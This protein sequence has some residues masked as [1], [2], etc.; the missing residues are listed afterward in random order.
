MKKY[1][2]LIIIYFINAQEIALK[3]NPIKTNIL[4]N[5]LKSVTEFEFEAEKCEALTFPLNI[6]SE[7]IDIIFNSIIENSLPK[8]N[9]EKNNNCYLVS[10]ISKS[11]VISG[12]NSDTKSVAIQIKNSDL[13]D[14]FIEVIKEFWNK[15]NSNKERL[16]IIDKDSRSI[17]ANGPSSQIKILQNYINALEA[18]TKKIEVNV[19]S[20][21][22]IEDI[23]VAMGIN[24]SGIYNRLKTIQANNQNFGFTG[25]SDDISD[26]PT[27]AFPVFSPS[28]QTGNL[29]VDPGNF[30]MNLYP[31][32]PNSNL[33]LAAFPTPNFNLPIVFGGPDLNTRRLNLLLN[34]AETEDKLKVLTRS[35]VVTN[36]DEVTKIFVGQSIPYYFDLL[37]TLQ[38][39]GRSSVTYFYRDIGTSLQ[40]KPTIV[41]ESKIN[42]EIY[43]EFTTINSGSSQV[44]TS[45]SFDSAPIPITPDPINLNW[46]E[47]RDSIT[48]ENGQTVII[49]QLDLDSKI[50]TLIKVPY[51]HRL[52]FVGNLFKGKFDTFA[53]SNYFVLLSA[54]IIE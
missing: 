44:V 4:L 6:R 53:R 41:N 3:N 22:Y 51:A 20:L 42:I 30:V 34:A 40:I 47:L 15:L 31:L 50:K 29:F 28:G 49:N 2:I 25:F 37:E 24:W 39:S 52:P 23:N 17:V 16:L 54:K 10:E 12:I 13:N 35:T 33:L 38:D 26:I 8:L 46:I 27:P 7:K 45:I 19:T 5:L 18:P 48:L 21:S 11:E 36:N 14:Q 43:I 9:F 1:T 32:S